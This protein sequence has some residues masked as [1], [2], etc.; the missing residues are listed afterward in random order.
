MIKLKYRNNNFLDSDWLILLEK[1]Y[2]SNLLD[3]STVTKGQDV[4]AISFIMKK[5]K[6][7]MFW[8]DLFNDVSRI[9]IYNY[10]RYIT[11]LSYNKDNVEI[12]LGRGLYPY[13]IRNFKPEYGKLFEGYIYFGFLSYYLSLMKKRI[14]RLLIRFYKG[15]NK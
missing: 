15:N 5:D 2:V 3:I 9:N 7:S 8:I 1:L 12:H 11:N 6:I 13:K 4:H 10:I 14:L